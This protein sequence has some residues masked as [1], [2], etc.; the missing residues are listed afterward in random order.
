M[1]IAQL[2]GDQGFKLGLIGGHHRLG[3]IIDRLP[4]RRFIG[5]FGMGGQR[6]G[7]GRKRKRA[8]GGQVTTSDT[9]LGSLPCSIVVGIVTGDQRFRP[10]GSLLQDQAL[11]R[12]AP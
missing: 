12:M 8:G 11:L 4:D 7:G 1:A 2:I 6:Q 3:E 9:H 10:S 5:G